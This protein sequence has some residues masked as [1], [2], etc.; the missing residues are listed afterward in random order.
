M[1][2]QNEPSAGPSQGGGGRKSVTT[3]C[4]GLRGWAELPLFLGLR[5]EL[6][7]W[8]SWSLSRK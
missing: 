1:E 5:L 3:V 6:H 4:R 7:S 2:T 8:L